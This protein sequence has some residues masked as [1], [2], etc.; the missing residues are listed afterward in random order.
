M[1]FGKKNDIKVIAVT[2]F[3]GNIFWIQVAL[4]QFQGIPAPSNKVL[5]ER[6]RIISQY[7]QIKEENKYTDYLDLGSTVEFPV[8]IRKTIGNLEYVIAIDSVVITPHYSY[9]NASMMFK[10]P[11]SATPIV[12]R[13]TDIRFTRQGG[14]SGTAKL[15]L[16]GDYL[17]KTP[18]GRIDLY[19]N[20]SETFVEWDCDGFK[21]FQLDGSIVFSR[22]LLVPI[23]QSTSV[24][25]TGQVEAAFSIAIGNW[26]DLIASA[27]ITPFQITSLKDF[28]FFVSE[29]TIDFSDLRNPTGASFSSSYQSKFMIPGYAELWRGAYLNGL[30][31]YLP[32]QFDGQ[33]NRPKIRASRLWIDEVGLSGD[34]AGQYLLSLDDG[35][36]SMSGWP[37]SLDEFKVSLTANKL[38]Y[39]SFNGEILLPV[40]DA[41]STL[42][43]TGFIDN[44]NT[45]FF[46]IATTDSLKIDLWKARA[47]LYESSF[48]N[49]E[50]VDGRFRPTAQLNGKLKIA[51]AS[52]DGPE[53]NI[54]E[55]SFEQLKIEDKAP[56]VTA[57]IFSP[58]L[59]NKLPK[60][61][62]FNFDIDRLG[63]RKISD[64]Q[65]ALELNSAILLTGQK[66][67]AF[68]AEGDIEFLA[69]TDDSD[70]RQKLVF[71]GINVKKASLH[72]DNGSYK[73]DGQISHYTNNPTFGNG[74]HGLIDAEFKPGIGVKAQARFGELNGMRFWYADA[75]AKFSPAIPLVPGLEMSGFGGGASYHMKRMGLTQN[76]VSGSGIVY[77][78]TAEVGLNIRAAVELS[79]AMGSGA[80]SANASFELSFLNSGGLRSINFRG[81]GVF[82]SPPVLSNSLAQL[83]NKVS[84]MSKYSSNHQQPEDLYKIPNSDR[85]SQIRGDVNI[86]YDFAN[87]ILHGQFNIYVNTPGGIIKGIGENGRAGWGVIHFA[88]SEWYVHL[89]KPNN[90]IGLR[91]G[92]GPIAATTNAYFMAGDNLP[93]PPPPA[94]NVSQ[95]LG[96]IDLDYMRDESA[97]AAGRGFALGA[98]LSFD[99]GDLEFWKFYG[100]FNAGA[101]FDLMLRNYGSSVSCLNRTGPIGINGWYANGQAYGYFTGNIGIKVDL[102]NKTQRFDIIN[103][104]AA[105][106]LQAK[107]PNPFWMRGIVGGNF[108]LLNGLISGN[109]RF[110][111][112]VGEE[113]DLPNASAVSGLKVIADL[114]PKDNLDEVDVFTNPQ[115]VFNLPI[116]KEFELIDPDNRQKMFRVKLDH[117]R[118]QGANGKVTGEITWNNSSDVALLIPDEILPPYTDLVAEVQISYEE[119]QG[120]NWLPVTENGN[121]IIEKLSTEF[122]TG[123]APDMIPYSNI[124]YAYPTPDMTN[125][126]PD[127][128]SAGYIQLIKGQ[129][130]LFENTKN[131]RVGI[132]K[133]D[134]SELEFT[135]RYNSTAKKL[136]YIIPETKLSTHYNLQLISRAAEGLGEI[137]KNVVS[138]QVQLDESEDVKL[139][140]KEAKGDIVN[141]EDNIIY[142]AEFQS[143]KF[144]TFSEKMADIEF[145]YLFR[146]QLVDWDVHR[147]EGGL[148]LS[149]EF[150]PEEL[151]GSRFTANEPLL[152]PAALNKSWYFAN[153]VEPLVYTNYPI[154]NE[155]H[156][157]KRDTTLLGL[158]PIRAVSISNSKVYYELPVVH[159]QD[160][161]DIRNQVIPRYINKP[162]PLPWQINQLLFYGYPVMP[163]GVYKIN[164]DYILPGESKPNSSYVMVLD[165]N[166]K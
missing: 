30:E 21:Q 65:I 74:F 67:G 8:G 108:S 121:I 103:L 151:A 96:G 73:L 24:L 38:N 19:L 54:P 16:V 28:S 122:K 59:T 64:R 126:L 48:I 43:Y 153:K 89:G 143:S 61:A 84:L 148:I 139:K 40:T 2:L 53:I 26:N 47:E 111:L 105:A 164:F 156:I 109:C 66:G 62:G 10:P 132:L 3:L 34:F 137:D 29:L 119:K 76:S 138:S 150:S 22:D 7:Q 116:N 15:E 130:Y 131:Q 56:F 42:K 123:E 127:E 162:N 95:I 163:R 113:C 159:Q 71:E 125:Y 11:Q 37:F 146:D 51:S 57:G 154:D 128:S 85:D 50:V 120:G 98:A 97:L 36:G 52:T 155:V 160:F 41:N 70:A 9:L 14:L 102:F 4:A 33:T 112:T 117:F 1:I 86:N 87:R 124:A 101:G 82:M 5:D 32:P 110:E 145:S 141:K 17:I 161:K 27:A 91:M 133:D 118:V 140:T 58:E 134:E 31:I 39:A 152:S 83:Q 72:I 99:T 136:T 81:E 13:G 147:L 165:F 80:F 135:F 68:V 44:S 94:E 46:N 166:F 69:I 144:Q 55:I 114:S 63:L 157:S 35:G 49:V 107:L 60:L 129:N 115:V 75:L 12:F 78:P 6:Q 25:P 158:V 104:S 90:R 106:V 88:P 142:N 79:S 93:Q 92:I 20:G 77:L 149:E 45:Y 100:R 23:D 18:A